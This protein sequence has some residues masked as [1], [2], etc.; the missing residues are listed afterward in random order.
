MADILWFFARTAFPDR[1]D[2]HHSGRYAEVF[3]REVDADKIVTI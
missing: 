2:I 3:V 1:K